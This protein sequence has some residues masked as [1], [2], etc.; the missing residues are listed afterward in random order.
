MISRFI[1]LI[2]IRSSSISVRN[3]FKLD[4]QMVLSKLCD[5]L[6]CF[7]YRI[8]EI[9][10][11]GG[12]LSTSFLLTILYTF[13]SRFNHNSVPNE[14]KI[15]ANRLFKQIQHHDKIKSNQYSLLINNLLIILI[16]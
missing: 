11:V 5:I 10:L 16:T 12:E 4:I 14:K 8:L 9:M 1:D 2:L 13:F 6:S 15:L 3:K 7:L